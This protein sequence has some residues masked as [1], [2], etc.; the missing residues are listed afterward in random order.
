MLIVTKGLNFSNSD[1]DHG[2]PTSYGKAHRRVLWAGSRSAHGQIAVSGI[3]KYMNY[4]VIFKVR[5]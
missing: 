1:L 5:L 2:S 4:F 3:S